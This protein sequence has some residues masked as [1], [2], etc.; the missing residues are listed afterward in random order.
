[1]KE[2]T[3]RANS[4]IAR[5]EGELAESRS[6]EQQLTSDLAVLESVEKVLGLKGV[7]AHVLGKAL[8]GI[9]A[10]AN[11]WL[12]RIAG[13]GLRLKLKPY[14]EKKSGELSD[15]IGL[16]VEGAGG[17]Y[18][19]KATSGGERRRLDIALL[20][21]LAEVA[22]AASGRAP[23]T[24]FCDEMFDALDAGGVDAV[25]SALEKLAESRAVVV[26]SHSPEL[27][28]RVNA[29]KRLKVENGKVLEL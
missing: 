27:A 13:D 10:S 19:Y 1:L 15:A 23:G 9:E 3:D 2:K 18:G 24:I 5:L 25:C 11:A 22:G 17:G 6:R 21:A 8:S 12:A 26:I 16:E 20:F 29:V 7:R 28:K 14:S 4:S